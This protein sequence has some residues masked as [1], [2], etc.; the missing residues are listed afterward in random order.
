MI[1]KKLSGFAVYRNLWTQLL[2]SIGAQDPS[3]GAK[4]IT[5]NFIGLIGGQG[6]LKTF[7]VL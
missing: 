7:K 6:P 1:Q 2:G 5:W 3:K 4:V